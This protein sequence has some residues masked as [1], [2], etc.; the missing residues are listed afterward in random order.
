METSYKESNLFTSP[1]SA[2]FVKASV[3]VVL[4]LLKSYFSTNHTKKRATSVEVKLK[5]LTT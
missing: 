4:K 5:F 2:S 1:C 3:L